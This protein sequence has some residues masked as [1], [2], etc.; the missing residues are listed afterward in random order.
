MSEY[1]PIIKKVY[2]F[3][4]KQLNS[5]EPQSI[6]YGLHKGYMPKFEGGV[7]VPAHQNILR[8]IG[9]EMRHIA[10]TKTSD[11]YLITKL[12]KENK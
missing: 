8:N 7:G 2:L 4:N 5:V 11:T 9:L 3:L 1:T 12:K 10:G 6:G